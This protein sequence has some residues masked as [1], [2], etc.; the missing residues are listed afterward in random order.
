MQTQEAV[1]LLEMRCNK[2]LVQNHLQKL[3]NKVITGRDIANIRSKFI[4]SCKEKDNLQAIVEKLRE[5]EG[6]DT[7]HIFLAIK[8]YVHKDSSTLYNTF[9]K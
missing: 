2:T 5:N 1:T 6:K 8:P 4:S 3:T 7:L 9:S